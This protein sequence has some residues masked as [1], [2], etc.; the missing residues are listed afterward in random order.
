VLDGIRFVRPLLGVSRRQILAYCLSRGL[1]W[2]EDSTNAD[3]RFARNRI[4]HFLLPFLRQHARE[5]IDAA[6]IEL[7]Q[8]CRHLFERVDEEVG[9]LLERAV[10]VSSSGRIELDRR[11]LREVQPLVLGELFVRCLQ[12]LETGLQDYSRRHYR[13][14]LEAVY[15]GRG[16][17]WSFPGEVDCVIREQRVY[18]CRKEGGREQENWEPVVVSVGRVS[19]WGPW[20]I[21]AALLEGACWEEVSSK[22]PGGW[23]EYFDA[24]RICWPVR[25]RLRRAGDK[26]VPLGMKKAKKVGKFLTSSKTSS[27][28][29]EDCLIV[30]DAEKILWVAPLRI[31]EEAKIDPQTKKTLR[32]SITRQGGIVC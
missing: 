3:I 2:R 26:F 20:R 30:E 24:E 1:R 23:T 14:F 5:P 7:S 31:S 6:L 19:Q 11:I 17:R 27:R 9:R 16:G 22:E 15:Q 13:Q 29:K 21:E 8:R 32:I 28:L 12:Q 25:V 4:R 10:C 18:L